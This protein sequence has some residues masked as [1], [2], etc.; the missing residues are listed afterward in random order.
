MRLVVFASILIGNDTG[1]ERALIILQLH[2]PAA[3]LSRGNSEGIAKNGVDK[4]GRETRYLKRPFSG[5][6]SNQ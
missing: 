6:P 3:T 4:D 2:P 5:Q 1:H